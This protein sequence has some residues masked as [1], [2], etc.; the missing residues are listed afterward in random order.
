MSQDDF[1]IPI[2]KLLVEAI[3]GYVALSFMD[4]F[5]SY[6]QIK[7]DP[8]EEDLTT[9]Q[10]PQSIYYYMVMLSGLKNVGAIYQIAMQIYFSWLRL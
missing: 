9:F 10:T 5:L 4:G 6:N 8:E 1:P 3:T 2:T 7:M